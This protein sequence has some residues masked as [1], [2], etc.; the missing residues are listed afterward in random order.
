ME[1]HFILFIMQEYVYVLDY[2][3]YNIFEFEINKNMNN[4]VK[5][6]VWIND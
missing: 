5:L 3:I 6:Q 2:I 1:P 4:K